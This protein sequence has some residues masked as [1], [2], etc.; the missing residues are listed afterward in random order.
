[1]IRDFSEKQLQRQLRKIGKILI[2]QSFFR[3]KIAEKKLTLLK[4]Q[5]SVK[6]FFK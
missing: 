4:R 1:M 3:R 2:I 5:K 6:F